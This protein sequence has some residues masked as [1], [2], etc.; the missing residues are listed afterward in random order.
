MTRFTPGME[1]LDYG[2]L[3]IGR[4]ERCLL[5]TALGA[6]EFEY[7][8]AVVFGGS[9][10]R[11]EAG[12]GVEDRLEADRHAQGSCG[13]ALLVLAG[14]A[15][16]A[17]R[18]GCDAHLTTDVHACTFMDMTL[19]TSSSRLKA[20]LGQ[21][22]RVVRS[23]KEVVVT[24]RDEPVARLIPYR[25]QPPV[26]GAEPQVA[27]PRDPGAPPL[28]EVAVQAIRYRG[29]STISLLLEDRSRR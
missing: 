12:D 18:R 27:Q 20:K 2:R 29:R 15:S 16:G 4:R 19:R 13:G 3:P 22:M 9:P 6:L 1:A 23:G 5:P 26:A 8:V 14:S 17:P 24:D 11:I 7:D 10:A 25:E 21:Y 28:G